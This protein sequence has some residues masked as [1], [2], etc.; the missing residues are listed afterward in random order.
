MTKTLSL[1]LRNVISTRAYIQNWL[2]AFLSRFLFSFKE[3]YHVK[4]LFFSCDVECTHRAVQKSE[5]HRS[6]TICLSFSL[7]KTKSTIH[8]NPGGGRAMKWL[9]TKLITLN[10]FFQLTYF[11]SLVHYSQHF[12]CFLNINGRH[13]QNASASVCVL[14]VGWPTRERDEMDYLMAIFYSLLKTGWFWVA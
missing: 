12:V 8:I 13:H 9:F 6:I 7:I 11:F 4:P 10:S 14:C 3:I 1:S 5:C 2:V